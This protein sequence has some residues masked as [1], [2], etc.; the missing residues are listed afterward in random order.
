MR[1]AA[2][3]GGGTS[4]V[5]AIAVDDPT[6]V[7]ERAD[8]PTTTP[9]ETIGKCVAWLSARQYDALGVATFGP[10]DLAPHSPT[11]GYIT[12]TPKPGWKNVD[13]LGPLR[14]VRPAAP[15][16]FDTDVNAPAVAEHRAMVA[17]AKARGDADL[18]TSCAYI[19]VGTG[20][21]VGLVVNGLPVHGLM[22]PEGGHVAVPRMPG[23]QSFKGSNPADCFDGSCAENMCCSLAL[24]MRAKLGDTSGLAAL[25]DDH[26]AWE[27]AAHYIGC[28][29]ASIVLMAAP[30]RIVLSGGVMLRSILFPRVR[31]KMQAMLNGYIKL[32]QI[33][34]TGPA[35]VD[36]YLVPS[37][38]GNKAGL[39]GALTLAVQA[40]AAKGGGAAGTRSTNSLVGAAVLVAVTS[41]VTMVLLRKK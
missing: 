2:V 15:V 12:T 40:A 10:V 20:I 3:E 17:D 4:W 24:A 25:P 41:V 9:A 23:D 21:G 6:N 7:V 31:A 38:W 22:H 1:Y 14:A 29:C 28:L 32:P 34:G 37:R 19:T 30:E 13:V 33:V 27:A 26:P 5:V 35:G 36:S 39:T 18:P 8:F 16:A 11:Y